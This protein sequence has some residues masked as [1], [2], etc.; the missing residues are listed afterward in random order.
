MSKHEKSFPRRRHQIAIA[1]VAIVT[2][3]AL[4]MNYYLW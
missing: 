3:I 4:F 2:A 1:V